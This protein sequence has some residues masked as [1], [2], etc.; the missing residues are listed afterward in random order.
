MH[1]QEVRKRKMKEEKEKWKERSIMKEKKNERRQIKQ[2]V[3]LLSRKKLPNLVL[4]SWSSLPGSY[5][6]A[7]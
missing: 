3:H 6:L 5:L 2:T 4:N 1:E 7:I